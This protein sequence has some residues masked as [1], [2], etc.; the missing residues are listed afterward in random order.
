MRYNSLCA[1]RSVLET[2]VGITSTSI[3]VLRVNS[4][5]ASRSSCRPMAVVASARK[6]IRRGSGV[7]LV[8]RAGVA[9]VPA[10]FADGDH[11]KSHEVT[12]IRL[13]APASKQTNRARR[14]TNRDPSAWT[15]MHSRHRMNTN[16]IEACMLLSPLILSHNRAAGPVQVVRCK[17]PCLRNCS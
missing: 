14:V 12:R 6:R 10:L 1:N 17:R 13:K 9:A 7:P 4:A 11:G 15:L 5:A 16:S 2:A 3:P 8:A